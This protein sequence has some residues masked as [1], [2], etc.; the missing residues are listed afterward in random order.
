MNLLYI[1]TTNQYL[2][3]YNLYDETFIIEADALEKSWQDTQ[4]TLTIPQL[5][6]IFPTA[7]PIVERKLKADIKRYKQDLAKAEEVRESFNNNVMSK[8]KTEHRWFWSEIRDIF[9]IQPLTE[10]REQLIKRCYFLLSALKPT[11]AKTNPDKITEADIARAKLVPV[12][13]FY[14]GKLRRAGNTLVGSCPLHIEK[15]P[16]FTI[17]PKTN[18]WYCYGG[19]GGGD[20]VDLVMRQSN[21]KFLEA[22]KLVLNK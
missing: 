16:S 12:E 20:T 3:K 15:T 9:F 22:V 7:K 13:Q 10:N 21:V 2:G 14:N 17:Y 18:R 8:V 11:V 4:Q 19:C 6:E 5:L 1:S